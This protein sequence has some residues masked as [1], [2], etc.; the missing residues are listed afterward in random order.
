[1]AVRDRD[2]ATAIGAAIQGTVYDVPVIALALFPTV[3]EALPQLLDALGG[4]GRPAGI[5][6]C[7]PIDG[8]AIVEWNPEVSDARVVIGTADVE[9]ARFKSGRTAELLTPLAPETAAK[10]AAIGLGAPQIDP[11]RILELRTEGA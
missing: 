8:G 7:E 2:D 4:E 1:V 9:L 11:D 6:A 10:L 3:P 5:L